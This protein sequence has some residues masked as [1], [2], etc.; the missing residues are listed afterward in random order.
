M[1]F[2]AFHLTTMG[3]VVGSCVGAAIYRMANPQNLSKKIATLAVSILISLGAA[4]LF[5]AHFGRLAIKAASATILSQA[6]TPT[7]I[8]AGA[9]FWTF[10]VIYRN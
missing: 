6:A 8:T 9:V 5:Y 4:S 7:H 3:F 1:S 2:P 10:Y